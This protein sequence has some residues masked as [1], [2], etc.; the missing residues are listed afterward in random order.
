M[1][2]KLNPTK[3]PRPHNGAPEA[4]NHRSQPPA[5]TLYL[6]QLRAQAL[7]IAPSDHIRLEIDTEAPEEDAQPVKIVWIDDSK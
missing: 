7:K 4:L 6:M 1:A 2:R 3:L 5:A